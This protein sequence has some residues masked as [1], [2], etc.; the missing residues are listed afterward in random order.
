MFNLS[1]YVSGRNDEDDDDESDS[2]LG[3][4]SNGSNTSSQGWTYLTGSCRPK[5]FISIDG[6]DKCLLNRA[7][8]EAPAVL[9]NVK[10]KLGYSTQIQKL[11]YSEKDSDETRVL[12]FRNSSTQKRILMRLKYSDSETQVLRKRF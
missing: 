11:E 3:G 5:I 12:R 7:R 8:E 9:M 10:K 4:T 1:A 6:V 2:E